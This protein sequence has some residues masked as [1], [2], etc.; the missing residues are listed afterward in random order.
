MPRSKHWLKMWV[1]WLDDPKMLRLTLAEQACWWRLVS[2]AQ[3][4]AAGGSLVTSSGSPLTLTEIT[5]SL[6]ISSPEEIAS[7]KSMLK[8]MEVAGSLFW[9]SETLH[10]IHFAERQEMV[11]SR[12]KEALAER[13]RKHRQAKKEGVSQEKRDVSHKIRD[14]SVTPP[15]KKRDMSQNLALKTEAKLPLSHPPSSPLTT[16]ISP[17]EGEE[18]EEEERKRDMSQKSRDITKRKICY[19]GNVYLTDK[20]YEK[21][22]EQFGDDGTKDR[23]EALSLYIASKGAERKYKS[24]SATILNWERMKKEREVK[25]ERKG[26]Q[27]RDDAAAGRSSEILRAKGWKVH[28]SGPE[29]DPDQ[30]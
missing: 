24:H 12:T 11:P 9:N 4:C 19:S 1:E 22:V 3:R 25:D 15:E 16:P 14:I 10:I 18:E 8:K 17:P 29:P 13:Q 6:R 7:F 21:L 5:V 23:I 28:E 27:R 20:E 2:F 26:Q 30:D